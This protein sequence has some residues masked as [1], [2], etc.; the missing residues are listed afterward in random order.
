ME[1]RFAQFSKT[2]EVEDMMAVVVEYPQVI[3][4][5]KVTGDNVL[6]MLVFCLAISNGT[7][8]ATNFLTPFVANFSTSRGSV[9][10]S[11]KVRMSIGPEP[12]KKIP[13][14]MA[15]TPFSR[16]RDV[17]PFHAHGSNRR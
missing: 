13:A 6:M 14:F 11:Y 5:V 1:N 12:V 2:K 15:H 16:L 17:W 9:R 8:K 10:D 7:S 3:L 4:L